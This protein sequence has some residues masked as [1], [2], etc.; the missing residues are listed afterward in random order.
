V[1]TRGTG[2][3]MEMEMGLGDWGIGEKGRNEAAPPGDYCWA[4]DLEAGLGV[5]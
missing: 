2:A 1:G 5:V 4:C 3:E